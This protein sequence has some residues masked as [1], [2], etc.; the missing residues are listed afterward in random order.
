MSEVVQPLV[1]IVIPAYNAGEFI[2]ETIDS[3]LQQT[4]QNFEII[5]IDDGSTDESAQ[6]VQQI[7]DKRIGYFYKKNEGVS[8]ARNYGYGLTKGKY[9]VFFDADDLMDV[10]FLEVRVRCLEENEHLGFCCGEV[11][12]FPNENKEPIFG[13]FDRVFDQLL[14]NK[15]K[16]QIS[17]CPSNYLFRKETL[18]R[19]Q[20]KYNQNLSSTADR[21]FLLDLSRYTKG[22][23]VKNSYLKYRISP[24]SMSAKLT[25]KLVDDNEQYIIELLNYS[26]LSSVKYKTALCAQFYM[27]AG[28][29]RSIKRMKRTFYYLLK[30]LSCSPSTFV[31]IGIN[32]LLN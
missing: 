19:T 27:L 22:A 4:Y 15:T 7:Q 11:L 8:I 14:L 20:V 10:D 29:N 2:E 3:M 5:V 12:N 6:K 16:T 28:A 30:I 18:E 17:T 26:I 9:V 32:K 13:V 21:F 24:N 31:K 1:S 23:I 25:P